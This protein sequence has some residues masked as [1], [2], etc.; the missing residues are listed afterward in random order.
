MSTLYDQPVPRRTS[1]AWKIGGW[2]G[3]LKGSKPSPDCAR[4]KSA[5]FG[6]K[7]NDF[8]GPKLLCDRYINLPS[9]FFRGMGFSG[10]FST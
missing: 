2:I 6:S 5:I 7:P 9:F 4:P 10:N 3:N 8:N 1:G